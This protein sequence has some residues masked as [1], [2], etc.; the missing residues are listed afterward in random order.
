MPIP[1][2]SPFAPAPIVPSLGIM[3]ETP[4]AGSKSAS[5]GAIRC[6]VCGT[7]SRHPPFRP[8]PPEQA[9]DLDLRPGEPVRSSMA[10]WLQ[11]CPACGYAAPDITRVLRPVDRLYQIG[12]DEVCD[13]FFFLKS[14]RFS[15][16]SS[17]VGTRK[18][19]L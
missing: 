13:S 3:A 9:P 12:K 4:S 18:A 17:S 8:P 19:S 2:I 11:Q 7:E 1:G 14:R 5:A 16:R 10:R 15:A 6:G